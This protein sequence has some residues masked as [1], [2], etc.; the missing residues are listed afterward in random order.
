M[1]YQKDVMI[2]GASK[3]LTSD[4]QLEGLPEVRLNKQRDA[5]F[6][7]SPFIQSITLGHRPGLQHRTNNTTHM[8][9]PLKIV[10]A[11]SRLH[12][13]TRRENKQEEACSACCEEHQ[14]VA[15]TIRSPHIGYQHTEVPNM[16]LKKSNFHFVFFATIQNTTRQ[17]LHEVQFDLKQKRTHDAEHNT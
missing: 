2:N 5:G 13:V 16:P 11:H 10:K 3:L 12:I 8:T 7:P 1:L 17:Q 4:S 9:Q 6:I 15:S 14:H